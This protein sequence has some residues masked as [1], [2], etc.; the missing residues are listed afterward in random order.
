MT[1]LL[2]SNLMLEI[3]LW[4]LEIFEYLKKK[5]QFFRWVGEPTH[6]THQPVVGWA[7]LQKI[8]LTL[9]WVGL[10]SLVF[11]PGSWWANPCELGWLTLTCVGKHVLMFMLLLHIHL[12]LG[13]AQI[14][15]IVNTLSYAYFYIREINP[16]PSFS[17]YSIHK[18][19]H[20][21]KLYFLTFLYPLSRLL[22]SFFIL[23]EI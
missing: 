1:S 16:I 18:N 4:L 9:K 2:L 6:L 14:L 21:T 5:I 11:W 8:W 13:L 22:A 7:E 17:I 15:F 20:L 12:Y 23:L 10:G 19:H 3:L